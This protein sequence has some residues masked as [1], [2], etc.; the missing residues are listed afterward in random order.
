M[1]QKGRGKVEE[2]VLLHINIQK[3][4][5]EVVVT[6]MTIFD[7]NEMD[8]VSDAYLKDLVKQVSSKGVKDD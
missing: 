3:I 4:D 2:H 6:L 8:N 5:D 1:L 7:K